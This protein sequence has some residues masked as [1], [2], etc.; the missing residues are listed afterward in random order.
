MEFIFSKSSCWREHITEHTTG[1]K[2]FKNIYM[3][4][5]CQSLFFNEVTG[6]K[7]TTLSKK[8]LRQG[9]FLHFFARFLR[10][11]FCR[12][13]LDN[14]LR[15]QNCTLQMIVMKVSAIGIS[16]FV[17]DRSIIFPTMCWGTGC[18]GEKER[19]L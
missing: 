4:H 10:T 19:G 8:G 9:V 18:G 16:Y 6:L 13:P 14:W 12:T 2:H 15:Y 5:L 3:K 1:V 17:Q 7:P 11:L